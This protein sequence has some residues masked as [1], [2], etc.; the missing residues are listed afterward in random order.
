M[1]STCRFVCLLLT[2]VSTCLLLTGCKWFKEKNAAPTEKSFTYTDTSEVVTATEAGFDED[3]KT[4]TKNIV[5][6]DFNF[7]GLM[8]VAIVDDSTGEHHDQV[9]IYIQKAIPVD[10]NAD[11]IYYKAG[12]IRQSLEGNI[13]G[14]MSRKQGRYT[15]LTVLI[16]RENGRNRMILYR[17]DG[18]KFTEVP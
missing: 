14:L 15:D 17:N 8:D 7:D 2:I 6:A 3:K 18:Q 4:T 11:P 10:P 5:R 9:L 12:A 1:K 13:I 16:K